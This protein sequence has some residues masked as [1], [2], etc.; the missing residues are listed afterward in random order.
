MSFTS[1]LPTNF[2]K[3]SPPKYIPIPYVVVC[4]IEVRY[5]KVGDLIDPENH[6]RIYDATKCL[7]RKS[8]AWSRAIGFLK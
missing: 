2:V 6:R 4:G 1:S 8:I 7:A 5:V 3:F